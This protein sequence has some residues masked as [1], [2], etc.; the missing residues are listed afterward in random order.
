MNLFH[1]KS[2]AFKNYALG[3]LIA[4][5]ATADLAREKLR[6]HFDNALKAKNSWLYGELQDDED[7]E[8][9]AQVRQVFEQDLAVEPTIHEAL[10]IEGG[11]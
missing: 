10:V 2:V 7:R 8:S 5:A 6:A 1:W 3:N 4:V 11:E 9:I